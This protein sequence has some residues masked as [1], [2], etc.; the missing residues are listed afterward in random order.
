MAGSETMEPPFFHTTLKAL[1]DTEAEKVKLNNCRITKGRLNEFA[2]TST[3]WPGTKCTADNVV[4]MTQ[5]L[6]I[7]ILSDG[8]EITH[9]QEHVHQVLQEI[10]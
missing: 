8:R 4:P 5:G 6:I 3:N 10:L 7:L 1:A 9:R 2:I